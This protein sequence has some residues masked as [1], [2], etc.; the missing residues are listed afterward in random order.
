MYPRESEYKAYK[1]SVSYPDNLK[2]YLYRSRNDKH[3]T[4][5]NVRILNIVGQAYGYLADCA[6]IV[7]FKNKTE[8]F[9]TALV[10][11]V[12]DGIIDP[13]HYRYQTV[14][15]PFLEELGKLFYDYELT[16]PK[17]YKPDLSKL[18]KAIF[19]DLK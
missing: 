15:F 5:E 8:F 6:Y 18:H 3:I 9:L 17:L 13:S 11:N 16:R 4:D 2:K 12:P 7:D 14:G 19:S 1:D 10:Y